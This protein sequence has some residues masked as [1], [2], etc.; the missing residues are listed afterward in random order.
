MKADRIIELNMEELV[1]KML[2]VNV[3]L[4]VLFAAAFHVFAQPFS[5]RPSWGGILYFLAGYVV[6]IVLHELFHLIG[7]VVFG[8]V[9][10]S[11]LQYG[12]NLKMGIAYATTRTPVQNKA[13]K[14]ALLLP[15]WTTAVLPTI[16]GFWLDSQVLVLLGA[17]LTAGAMGDFVM[18]RGLLKERNSAWIVDDPEKPKLHIYD[19]YPE[20][21]KSTET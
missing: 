1:L 5:F 18:Y 19:L 17:M 9:T 10:V 13:M 15:F 12:I 6:L 2:W 20:P 3:L 21:Q 16:V 4:L 7:F 8:K 14:K 11:S